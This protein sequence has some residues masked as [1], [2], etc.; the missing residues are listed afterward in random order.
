VWALALERSPWS[1]QSFLT[2]F[3]F[4]LTDDSLDAPEL[5][6]GRAKSSVDRQTKTHHS[7]GNFRSRKLSRRDGDTHYCRGHIRLM[8]HG[9]AGGASGIGFSLIC[10]WSFPLSRSVC[11]IVLCGAKVEIQSA[12]DIDY[13]ITSD[14]FEPFKTGRSSCVGRR[15]G[16]TESPPPTC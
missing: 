3:R 16:L 9:P 14:V 8:M 4:Y 1:P 12:S 5:R 15:G 11:S 10:G 7:A 6:I 13:G 2:S